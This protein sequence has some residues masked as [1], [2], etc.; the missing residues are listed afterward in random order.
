MEIFRTYID[1]PIGRVRIS[2]TERGITHVDFAEEK[3]GPSAGQPAAFARCVEQLEEY[4]GGV[5]T[6]PRTPELGAMQL[7]FLA[8]TRALTDELGD[9]LHS[10]GMLACDDQHRPFA[11]PDC[12]R[13]RDPARLDTQRMGRR[14]HRRGAQLGFDDGKVGRVFAEPGADGFGAHSPTT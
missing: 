6:S 11:H 8:R 10:L 4:F 7:L 14:F 5:R 9:A 12:Q 13:L 2:G 1:S 3:E